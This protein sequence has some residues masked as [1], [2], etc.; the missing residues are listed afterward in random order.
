MSQDP[1]LKKEFPT[2]E[3]TDGTNLVPISDEV[4]A[5]PRRDPT[6]EKLNSLQ[7][8]VDEKNAVTDARLDA[9]EPRSSKLE[10]TLKKLSSKAGSLTSTLNR[11]KERATA[12]ESRLDDLEPKNQS[13]ESKTL[14]LE[15]S[16][17]EL[18]S[19]AGILE[20]AQTAASEQ[21]KALEETADRLGADLQDTDHRMTEQIDAQATRLDLLEP[22]HEA[23]ARAL[24][25]AQ[26]AAEQQIK[27][28]E[29]TANSLGVSLRD[30]DGRITQRID[31]QETRL[32]LL[33]PRYET[34]AQDLEETQTT[35]S[36]QVKAL[37]DAHIPNICIYKEVFLTVHKKVD[38][39]MCHMMCLMYCIS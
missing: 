33:E 11:V 31:A 3:A 8:E 19:R 1:V 30:T 26:T 7:E 24:K 34:L 5:Q 39:K 22:R 36:Q 10:G 6:L 32:G 9:L 17:A 21:V 20:E 29:E 2:E 28:L 16:T 25:E 23:L 15:T 18:G 4:E 12:V 13:L 27:A 37:E 35:T 14:A 38:R